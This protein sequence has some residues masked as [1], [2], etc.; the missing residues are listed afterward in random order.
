[1]AALVV[2][3]LNLNKTVEGSIVISLKTLEYKYVYQ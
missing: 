3:R 1:M 2:A